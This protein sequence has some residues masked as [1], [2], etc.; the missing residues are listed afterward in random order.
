MSNETNEI[1]LEERRYRNYSGSNIQEYFLLTKKFLLIMPLFLSGF[2]CFHYKYDSFI[3]GDFNIIIHILSSFFIVLL[4]RFVIYP[5]ITL[6]I[7][8][9][10]SIIVNNHVFYFVF[11][12]YILYGIIWIIAIKLCDYEDGQRLYPGFA[13]LQT[14]SIYINHFFRNYSHFYLSILYFIILLYTLIFHQKW[15]HEY[16]FHSHISTKNKYWWFSFLSMFSISHWICSNQLTKKNVIENDEIFDIYKYFDIEYIKY[17]GLYTFIIMFITNSQIFTNFS[18]KILA[19]FLSFILLLLQILNMVKH[20]LFKGD[21]SLLD[22][23]A[24]GVSHMM[25]EPINMLIYTIINRE[26]WWSLVPINVFFKSIFIKLISLLPISYA[27]FFIAW[28]FFN[29]SIFFI[30]KEFLELDI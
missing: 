4:D 29:I 24:F 27:Y 5:S 28:S 6:S 2:C 19:F 16:S 10:I 18:W 23:L 14:P 12:Q 21:S 3:Y 25:F 30:Y 8:S 22:T 15:K 7:L 26:N 1:I 20:H 13:L 11:H 9:I 17:K